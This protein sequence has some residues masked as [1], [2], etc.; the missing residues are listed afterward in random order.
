[1]RLEG[2]DQRQADDR[3]VDD[4]RNLVRREVAVDEAA[5]G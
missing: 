2:D 4:P 1:M 3:A 5:H